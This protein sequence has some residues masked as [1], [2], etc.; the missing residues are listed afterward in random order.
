MVKKGF[1][2]K[3]EA[4]SDL[5]ELR[6]GGPYCI[7]QVLRG[8]EKRVEIDQCSKI[9]GI[10]YTLENEYHQAMQNWLVAKAEF[11]KENSDLAFD[12]A[13]PAKVSLKILKNKIKTM[14]K[15]NDLVVKY[16]K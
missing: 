15:A 14:D 5:T 16:D 10:K 3:D 4:R 2:S 7:Y 9:P 8:E 6:A 1:H 12:Q 11:E 13:A